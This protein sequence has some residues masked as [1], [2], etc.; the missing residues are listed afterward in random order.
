MS[1]MIHAPIHCC[2]CWHSFIDR[3]IAI[4]T[5]GSLKY[6]EINFAKKFL[7]IH[8]FNVIIRLISNCTF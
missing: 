7:F 5:V 2:V 4:K 3:N 8:L 6:P 1:N